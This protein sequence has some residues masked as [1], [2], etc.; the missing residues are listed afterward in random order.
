MT[1]DEATD[2]PQQDERAPRRTPYQGLLPYTEEDHKYFF[3]RA[4]WRGIITDHLLAY[5]VTVLYGPSGVGKSSVLRAGV[6][7]ELRQVASRNLELTGRAE[8]LPAIVSSWSGDPIA[9]VEAG[10]VAAAAQLSPS[11]ALNPPTGTLTEVVAGWADRVGGPVLL[12]FDQFDEYFMY[13]ER[14]PGGLAFMDQLA[15]VVA[16]RDVA[17]NVLISIR[18]DALAKLNR[19]GDEN[20]DLLQN[21]L[22]IDHLNYE[23][24]REAIEKPLERWNASE[25]AEGM[26]MTLEEGEPG[27]PGLVDAVLAEADA[28][29]IRIGAVGLGL[30]DADESEPAVGSVEAPYLQLVMTTL[31]EEERRRGSSVMRVATLRRLGGSEQIV[32][33]HFDNV[34]RALPRRQR[35]RASKFLEY[36]VTPAGTKIALPPSALAK[37]SKQKEKKITPILATLAGGQQRILRTVSVPGDAS[38]DTSYEIFHDRL[39]AGIL[40]WRRRNV[41]RRRRRRGLFLVALPVLV[42]VSLG[43]TVFYRQHQKNVRQAREIARI[44]REFAEFEARQ[45]TVTAKAEKSAFFVRSLP[46][47]SGSVFTAAFSPDGR[48]V[49]TASDDDS[50]VVTSIATGR[51]ATLDADTVEGVTRAV[52]SPDGR[53]VGFETGG[54]WAGVWDLRHPNRA[55]RH[56]PAVSASNSFAFMPGGRAITAADNGV[57]RISDSSTGDPVATL[58]PSPGLSG[59]PSSDFYWD[60]VTATRDGHLAAIGG[61]GLVRVW[62]TGARKLLRTLR[63]GKR[64]DFVQFSPDGKSLLT[65]TPGRAILWSTLTWRRIRTGGAPA[66]IL[67]GD[68]GYP[69]LGRLADFAGDK[70]AI[71]GKRGVSIWSGTSVL[72][73]GAPRQS[74]VTVVRLSP[75]GSVVVTGG[76]GGDIRAWSTQGKGK[77]LQLLLPGSGSPSGIEWLAFGGNGLLASAGR[78]GTSFVWK[79]EPDLKVA[80]TAVGAGGNLTVTARVTNIGL[81]RS[82]SARLELLAPHGV[83]VTVRPLAPGSSETWRLAVPYGGAL[84]AQIVLRVVPA[85]PKA[86]AR[87]ENN[88]ARVTVRPPD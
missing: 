74:R 38:G 59:H 83:L 46:P 32:R 22:P 48:R 23:S 61:V 29:A 55:I 8:I 2:E 62:D 53:A 82:N 11:L 67:T 20:L 3:G 52:F 85:N 64:P 31:W 56:M 16:D 1:A 54:G 9:S 44:Q 60:S 39:G 68:D 75:D 45:N 63:L 40:D 34:M 14:N 13:N 72:H 81:A 12:V 88:V 21:L 70:I 15:D 66:T 58:K 87:P 5:R 76:E 84:P 77:L 78:D 69:D 43:G 24:A 79:L 25:E 26:A 27:Q 10:L 49:V 28:R 47:H 6:V 36:L 7:H 42:A 41:R 57:V 51:Q 18:E 86:D 4:A 37:W 33:R 71:V 19:F 80:G 73:V 50:A 17:V 65:V 35:V 30:V